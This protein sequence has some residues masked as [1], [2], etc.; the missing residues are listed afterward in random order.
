MLTFEQFFTYE[1]FDIIIIIGA[2]ILI[3]LALIFRLKGKDEADRAAGLMF[4]GL[5]F[6]MLCSVILAILTTSIIPMTIIPCAITQGQSLYY[7][8]DTTG[9][10]YM[11]EPDTALKI[12]MN[13]SV[14]VEV[15]TTK[16]LQRYPLIVNATSSACKSSEPTCPL[17]NISSYWSY[18]NTS[19][20]MITLNPNA[21]Y[22]PV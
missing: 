12:H 8:A 18:Y 16:L 14:I 5:G 22:I 2:I 19:P 10:I 7:I 20:G 13:Q 6:A 11:S 3:I 21:T 9:N 17:Y 4:G 1:S 15:R